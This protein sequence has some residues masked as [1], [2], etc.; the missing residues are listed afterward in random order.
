MFDRFDILVIG[1]AYVTLHTVNMLITFICPFWPL[2][3]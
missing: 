1:F 3:V 2:K